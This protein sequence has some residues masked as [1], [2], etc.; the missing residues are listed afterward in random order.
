MPDLVVVPRDTRKFEHRDAAMQL[1]SRSIRGRS[2][3]Q[4]HGDVRHEPPPLLRRPVDPLLGARRCRLSGPLRGDPTGMKVRFRRGSDV[5]NVDACCLA[6]QA[7]R[8]ERP[9]WLGRAWENPSPPHGDRPLDWAGGCVP[10][11]SAGEDTTAARR[12]RA[13]VVSRAQPAAVR[14]RALQMW[15]KSDS[16][17]PRMA[18]LS[19]RVLQRAA[20]RDP[21]DRCCSCRWGCFVVMASCGPNVG[22][23]AAMMAVVV[24]QT[25]AE[26]MSLQRSAAEMP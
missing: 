5:E 14:A 15:L 12:A 19:R 10:E 7:A 2:H 21:S 24:W 18:A 1:E 23:R 9:T 11:R 20:L 3:C 16:G 6:K 25:T 17:H 4:I 13:H 22:T 8:N 26:R